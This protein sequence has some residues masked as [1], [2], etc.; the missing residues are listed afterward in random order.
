M[1]DWPMTDWAMT[2]WLTDTLIW[3]GALM[4]LALVLRG[5]VARVFGPA[6]AYA[7]WFLPLLRLLVPTAKVI[8]PAVHV[9]PV[10]APELASATAALPVAVASVVAAPA[11]VAFDPLPWLIAIWLIGAVIVLA[12]RF[13]AYAW[14]RR[15]LLANTRELRRIGRV[16]VIEST[17]TPMPIAFGVIDPCVAVPEGFFTSEDPLAAELALEHELQHHAGGD[18][19]VNLA[20]QPL[21][22]L[23][24]FNPLARLAWRALRSDQ[25]A[26]C[27]ARV[28][29]ARDC[30]QRARYGALL[31]RFAAAPTRSALAPPML[32][33][34][35]CPVGEGRSIIHRLRTLAMPQVSRRRRLVGRLLIGVGVLA[36]P[37]TGSVTYAASDQP[38][39][40]PLPSAPETP[41]V[42]TAPDAP[43][44]PLP[45]HPLSGAANG[46][47]AGH[48]GHRVIV[49]REH[50]GKGPGQTSTVTRGNTT[51]TVTTDHPVSDAE[52][53]RIVS[54]AR[55]GEMAA[56]GQAEAERGE[57]EAMRGVAQAQAAQGRAEAAEG[58]AEAARTH[59][60][61]RTEII[62]IHDGAMGHTMVK[63][64]RMHPLDAPGC[65]NSAP[66]VTTSDADGSHMIRI[67]VCGVRGAALDGLR[68][69]RKAIEQSPDI[70]SEGRARALRE[71]DARIMEMEKAG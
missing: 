62:R 49:I 51:V 1:T 65:V 24:W 7:L 43:L 66:D 71:I 25:E 35:A 15:R 9:A 41:P 42:P 14:M 17:A 54:D 16:R 37:L 29:A 48:P 8:L 53:D 68:H 11:L 27:D 32:S 19:L 69:A 39:R 46:S 60:P 59:A 56:R 21:F 6:A 47:E 63:L 38:A 58:R 44:P 18:L 52:I 33:P 3:T 34:L 70:P 57:A 20:M 40:P 22:A 50:A 4:A 45:P 13:G 36:L 5:P 31:A 67:K 61:A 2:D 64:R 30:D 26:A 28:V 55:N 10:H 23:H 12:R